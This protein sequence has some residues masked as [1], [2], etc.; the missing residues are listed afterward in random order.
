MPTADTAPSGAIP[1]AVPA[2]TYLLTQDQARRQFPSLF[3]GDIDE[4]P[5]FNELGAHGN[6]NWVDYWP[7]LVLIV[8]TTTG[9]VVVSSNASE[10][11]MERCG[12][13]IPAR[14]DEADRG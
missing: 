12:F 9:R 5:Y 3:E 2:L 13:P 11:H 14:G 8:A 4:D 6:A 1:G 7:D 10:W